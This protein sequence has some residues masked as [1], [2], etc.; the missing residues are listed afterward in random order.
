MKPNQLAYHQEFMLRR[1]HSL[2]GIVP[3][4]GFI[5]FHFF[6]NAYSTR[7]QLPYNKNVD[8]LR[9]LPFLQA[10]EWSLLLGPF[11]LHMFYGVWITFTARPNVLRENYAR[12]WAYFA[13]RVSAAVVFVFIVYHVVGLRFLEP[14]LDP[15]TGKVDY[16]D[17]LRIQFQN[18]WIYWWYVVGIG[19]TAFHLA[20]GICTF[21]MTWG[22]T[23]GRAAQKYT[24]YAMTAAG[25]VAFAM[26]VNA[27]NGFNHRSA[28]APE[29]H[30]E[31]QAAP[32]VAQTR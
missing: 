22:I 6:E 9:G 26:G 24:A 31:A 8:A 32:A 21:C 12:N 27:I 4:A 20:N 30:V 18:P 15:K 25:I 23:I 14:A 1:L 16:F 10:I 7:G 2:L 11:L 17:Y 5:F 19:C 13:Q 3:L 29:Q 28:T